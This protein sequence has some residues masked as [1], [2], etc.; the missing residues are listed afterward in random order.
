MPYG[1]RTGPAGMGPMTGRGMAYCA[2]HPHPGGAHP[3]SGYWGRGFGG[4]GWR[5][6][7]HATGLP[8]WMRGGWGASSPCAP[9]FPDAGWSKGQEVE[10]LKAQ[11]EEMRNEL[12]EIEKRISELESTEEE[13]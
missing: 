7:Y 1:D 6:C 4:R 12:K 2:G 8:G 3:G 11:A 13:K 9:P 10:M 5:Y